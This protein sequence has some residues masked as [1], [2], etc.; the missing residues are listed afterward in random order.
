MAILRWIL[1]ILSVVFCSLPSSWQWRRP[2]LNSCIFWLKSFRRLNN[3]KN[4]WESH[5]RKLLQFKLWTRHIFIIGLHHYGRFDG[6]P[7]AAIVDS[8]FCRSSDEL[9]IKCHFDVKTEIVEHSKHPFHFIWFIRIRGKRHFRRHV[10][11][12]CPQLFESVLSKW[13]A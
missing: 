11:N 12:N 10:N 2:A 6:L 1:T 4:V 7:C 9:S 13:A 5:A 3:M 8:F